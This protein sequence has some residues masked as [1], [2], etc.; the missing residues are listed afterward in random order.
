MFSILDLVEGREELLFKSA[1]AFLSYLR[2]LPDSVFLD[3]LNGKC[4]ISVAY[5]DFDEQ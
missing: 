4:L 5:G 3:F 2:S 1:G